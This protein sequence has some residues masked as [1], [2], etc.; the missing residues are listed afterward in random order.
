MLA[1]S[2]WARVAAGTVSEITN[3]KHRRDR[4]L[5]RRI[6]PVVLVWVLFPLAGNAQ[7]VSGRFEIRSARVSLS[8][9]VYFLNG[10]AEYRLPSAAR[11]AL[12][13]GLPLTIALDIELIRK[14][15][16]WA[17]ATEAELRQSY[18]LS[19][20]ALSQRYIV[21]NLNSGD[22][23]TY[24]TLF[25]ALNFLGRLEGLPLIDAE[26]LEPGAKYEVRIKAS[27]DTGDLPGPLRLLTFW[28]SDWELESEWYRWPL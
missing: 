17:D 21:A 15:R 5:L 25:S 13:S 10:R 8:G 20:H 24:A 16:F 28:R 22:R 27:L 2:R 26:L 7:D 23:L 9:G 6:L 4:G 1:W 18:E 11:D 14:R 12:A 19:Y 3:N